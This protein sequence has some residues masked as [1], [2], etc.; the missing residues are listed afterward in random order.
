[1]KRFLGGAVP[2]E[3]QPAAC[4]KSAYKI[5]ICEERRLRQMVLSI[6]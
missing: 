4:S 1:M 6:A 5:G 3:A 2:Q